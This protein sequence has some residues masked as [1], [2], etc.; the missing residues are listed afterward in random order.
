MTTRLQGGRLGS[1]RSI[2]MA[3]GLRRES[4]AYLRITRIS[5]IRR[6]LRGIWLREIVVEGYPSDARVSRYSERIGCVGCVS[7]G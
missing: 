4:T 5:A 7:P 3:S 6:G 2:G 1:R